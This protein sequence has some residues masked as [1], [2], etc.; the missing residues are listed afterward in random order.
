MEIESHRFRYQTSDV[1]YYTIGTGKPLIVL[2]GWGSS[3]S[4]MVP[5]A[6]RLAEHR[7]CIMI[8]FP[9]FG[10]S[11]EPP[12]AWSIKDYSDLVVAFIKETYPDTPV[13]MLVHSFGGRV[14]LKILSSSPREIVIEKMVV[15]GGAGLKPKR[16]L[17]FHLKRFA[18]KVLKLP[19]S[20]VPASKREAVLEKIRQTRAWKSLGSSDYSK[21]SGVMRETF[22]KSVTEF[23]DESLSTIDDEILLLWGEDDTA[24]PLDQARRLDEGLK[25]S[26][27]VTIENA[28]HYAFLDQPARFTSIVKAYLEG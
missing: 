11:P 18:A 7:C 10:D 27:L 21:L 15:T 22:V 28:G 17:T 5:L 14:L 4:V 19:A 2:H 3:S 8:D 26:A 24:T 12:T 6:K 1:A 9:G 20:L 16:S 23:F 13:D 25:N